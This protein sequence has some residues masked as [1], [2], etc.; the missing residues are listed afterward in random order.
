[1]SILSEFNTGVVEIEVDG[2]KLPVRPL[3]EDKW[4]IMELTKDKKLNEV[5]YEKLRGVLKKILKQ[6]LESRGESPTEQELEDFI[7]IY[8]DEMMLQLS[9]VF[10]WIS[11]NDLKEIRGR[12]LEKALKNAEP[13]NNS[14]QSS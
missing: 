1:M 14:E 9:V 8:E 11:Q 3:K 6:G 7:T 2:K 13:K 4:T 12:F 10:R 5:Q